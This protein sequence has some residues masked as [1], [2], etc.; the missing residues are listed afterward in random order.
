MVTHDWEVAARY[1]CHVLVLNQHL[2]GF[3]APAEILCGDCLQRAYGVSGEQGTKYCPREQE[4]L[5]APAD[6]GLSTG[7]FHD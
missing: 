3:G 6:I 4:G 5:Q 1:A 7:E 2:I